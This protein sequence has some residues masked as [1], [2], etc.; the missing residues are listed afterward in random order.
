MLQVFWDKVVYTSKWKIEKYE[1][2]MI[3]VIS[4]WQYVF[5]S[6]LTQ[7]Q[8]TGIW[9]HRSPSLRMQTKRASQFDL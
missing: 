4:Y 3:D 2:K 6:L 8:H 9:E 7:N 1:Q 5:L